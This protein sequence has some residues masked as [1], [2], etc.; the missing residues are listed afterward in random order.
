M[1]AA[2]L[3]VSRC[4]PLV[5]GGNWDIFV[6]KSSAFMIACVRSLLHVSDCIV[7][8]RLK[9]ILDV[10]ANKIVH[11]FHCNGELLLVVVE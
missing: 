8:L 3:F 1:I 6:R 9:G 4:F 11:A 10:A 5:M 7:M 2:K